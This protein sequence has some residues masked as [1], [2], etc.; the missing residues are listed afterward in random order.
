MARSKT[1][2]ISLACFT[3]M[4]NTTMRT[5]CGETLADHPEFKVARFY[6]AGSDV[7]MDDHKMLAA[8]AV[9]DCCGKSLPPL[10]QRPYGHR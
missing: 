1:M 4:V 6:D 8:L 5:V 10:P 3:T 2:R 7:S 9:T